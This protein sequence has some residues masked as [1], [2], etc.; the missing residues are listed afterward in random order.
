[1]SILY[2]KNLKNITILLTVGIIVDVTSLTVLTML[3]RWLEQWIQTP[4]AHP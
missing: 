4:K 2:L 3:C 1:M